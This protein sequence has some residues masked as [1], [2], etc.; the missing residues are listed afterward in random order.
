MQS[1]H[2]TKFLIPLNIQNSYFDVHEQL[3]LCTFLRRLI[4]SNKVIMI[5]FSRLSWDQNICFQVHSKD[6]IF[7]DFWEKHLDQ[8]NII[9]RIL[10]PNTSPFFGPGPKV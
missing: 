4:K 5:F 1:A 2:S 9:F 8:S 3:V 10:T 6:T 7:S